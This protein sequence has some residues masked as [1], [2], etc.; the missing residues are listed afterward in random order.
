M[1]R[2][3]IQRVAVFLAEH[4]H[5]H[6]VFR[7]HHLPHHVESL[8]A[9]LVSLENHL[10][11]DLPPLI[12]E[13]YISQYGM[14]LE[15]LPRHTLLAHWFLLVYPYMQIP[16]QTWLVRGTVPEAWLETSAYFNSPDDLWA[17]KQLEDEVKAW[18]PLEQYQ[19]LAE[20]AEAYLR[21][22]LLARLLSHPSSM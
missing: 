12:A 17:R 14:Y 11:T 10:R 18:R 22:H 6:R 21:F 8:E 5:I 20:S 13:P 1:Q 9:D 16:D 19:F 15:T 2:V 4:R 7:S 3:Q